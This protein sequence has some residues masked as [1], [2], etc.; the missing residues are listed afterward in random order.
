M[1]R[2]PLITT[3]TAAQFL[4]ALPVLEAEAA[5]RAG[6]KFRTY[7]PDAG[8]FRRELYVPHGLFMAAGAF[9]A[10][11]LFLA[12]N[13]IGKTDTAAYEICCHLTGLYPWW[14]TGKRFVGPTSWWAAGDTME[15]T[16]DV[17]QTALMGPHDDVPRATWHPGKAMIPPHLVHHTAR[18]SGGI[19]NCLAQV[20]V[21]HVDAAGKPDGISDL[22]FKSYDQGR[23]SF[24]GPEKHGIWLDEEPPDAGENQQSDIYTECLM[25]T[26]TVGG[27]VI[28][29]FTPLRG[30]TQFVQWYLEQAVMPEPGNPGKLTNAT[31]VF[32]PDENQAEEVA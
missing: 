19:P 9:H 22:A 4:A 5:R 15:T 2:T 10:E 13:R 27:I 25:R 29:T 31:Q 32:W 1:A 18:K 12:A 28:A 21:K 17:P 6:G 14:W 20:W 11:R 3:Q 30:L 16:R 7:F 24:Q 23:R 26:M 8:P